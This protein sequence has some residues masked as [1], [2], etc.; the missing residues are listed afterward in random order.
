MFAR[1]HTFTID[2]FQ[3]RPVTVEVDIRA[4][5]PAFA[6]V[7]LADA[8]VREARERVRAAI[9]NSGYEFPARRITANLA[10][11]DVPKAGPALDLPLACAVL[12]AR[13]GQSVTHVASVSVP[14]VFIR[15][16]FYLVQLGIWAWWAIHLLG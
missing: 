13:I 14:A 15:F 16:A 7:G 6:V 5:L 2:G 9:R 1:A 8:A 11:G 4:G 3:T 12:W 10:P